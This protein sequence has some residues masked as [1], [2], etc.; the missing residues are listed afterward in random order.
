MHAPVLQYLKHTKVK[1]SDSSN[2]LNYFKIKWQT[3]KSR[4]LQ[5]PTLNCFILLYTSILLVTYIKCSFHHYCEI[6]LLSRKLPFRYHHCITYP[7]LFP[8]LFCYQILAQ[9]FSGNFFCFF[10]SKTNCF[11]KTTVT[12]LKTTLT[13]KPFALRL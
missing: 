7:S 6:K 8:S 11:L 5:I 3:K 1:N 13:N 10:W 12:I 9:H 2:P 4:P